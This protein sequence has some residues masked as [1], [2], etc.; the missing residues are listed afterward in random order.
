MDMGLED[1]RLRFVLRSP[2]KENVPR[3]TTMTS[4]RNSDGDLSEEDEEAEIEEQISEA[5]NWTQSIF[6]NLSTNGP[7]GVTDPE[8]VARGMI[9]AIISE[10]GKES[11]M[12]VFADEG[13]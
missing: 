7:I 10:I 1:R 11:V 13:F 6:I 4:I 5:E 2:N 3:H 8:I 9:R 12:R